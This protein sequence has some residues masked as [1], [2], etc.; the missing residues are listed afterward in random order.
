MNHELVVRVKE[1]KKEKEREREREREKPDR[2]DCI[3]A[4]NYIIYFIYIIIFANVSIL[5]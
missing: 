1:T 4:Y 5:F 2:H 3:N